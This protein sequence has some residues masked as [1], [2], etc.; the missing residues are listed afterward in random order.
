[1]TEAT[2]NRELT[3]KLAMDELQHILDRLRKPAEEIDVDDL[4][5]DVNRAKELITYCE[6]KIKRA[7][8]QIQ[9]VLKQIQPQKDDSD[10]PTD[11]AAGIEHSVLD[12]EIEEV[13][14]VTPVRKGATR[15]PQEEDIP[16]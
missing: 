16:Y 10:K 13:P 4:L 3:Y 1:M 2:E 8:T 11:S 6:R 12:E 14:A 7:D 15:S 5:N 9:D